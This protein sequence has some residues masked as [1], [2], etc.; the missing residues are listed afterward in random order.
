VLR[1]PYIFL[2]SGNPGGFGG[3]GWAFLLKR[4]FLKKHIGG[5]SDM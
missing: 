2:G 3:G 1:L 5:I 4:D